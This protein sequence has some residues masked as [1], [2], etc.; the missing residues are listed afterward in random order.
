MVSV[1]PDVDREGSAVLLLG[2]RLRQYGTRLGRLQVTAD[3]AASK[4]EA[5]PTETRGAA[6]LK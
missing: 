6:L 3:R 2:L 4:H 1:S 5:R